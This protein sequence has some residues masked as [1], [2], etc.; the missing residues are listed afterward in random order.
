[1]TKM[2]DLAKEFGVDLYGWRASWLDAKE[3]IVP[4]V[5]AKDVLA[6]KTVSSTFEGMPG[7]IGAAAA[8]ARALATEIG[9]IVELGHE[10]YEQFGQPLDIKISE[11][12]P[13]GKWP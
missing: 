10:L 9:A 3:P 5:K 7:Q 12:S 13:F 8:K 6:F 4:G 2:G 1:M 11:S